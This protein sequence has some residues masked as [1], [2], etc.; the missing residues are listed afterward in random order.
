MV[1][2]NRTL[3]PIP[4]A[5]QRYALRER[6]GELVTFLPVPRQQ[7]VCLIA[8]RPSPHSCKYVVRVS[9]GLHWSQRTPRVW[10]LSP[11][12]DQGGHQQVPHVYEY[13]SQGHARL[14]V[15]NPNQREF[16]PEQ[17]L[18]ANSLVPWILTWLNTYE[19]W[20]L[21]GQW[22]YPQIHNTAKKDHVSH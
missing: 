12:L 17:H 14:C 18:L 16:R 3:K 9:Y 19:F 7:L 4:I 6:Y 11:L 15:Y 1:Q 5:A 8:L 21:T 22:V 10:L 13:N 2:K 20:L